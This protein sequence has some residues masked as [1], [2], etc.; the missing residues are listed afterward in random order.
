[1]EAFKS[2]DREGQGFISAA[3]M[4]HL[5]TAMGESHKSRYC[6]LNWGVTWANIGCETR[7]SHVQI[8][9]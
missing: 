2:F 6:V 8:M 7:L 1:M 9:F 5:L 3:E 4:R